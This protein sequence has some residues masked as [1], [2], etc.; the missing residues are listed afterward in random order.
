MCN[1][2]PSYPFILL[3]PVPDPPINPFDYRPDQYRPRP[4]PIRAAFNVAAALVLGFGIFTAFG[5]FTEQSESTALAQR[6]V[7]IME[8]RV[9]LRGLQLDK[10]RDARVALNAAKVKTGRLI[11]ANAVIQELD[12]G[13][14]DTAAI[15]VRLT[16]SNVD[17]TTVDDDG[18]VV[19]VEAKAGDYSILL[20]YI[21]LLEDVLQFV[22]VQVLK[23]AET[24]GDGSEGEL[25]QQTGEPTEGE[26]VV[27]MS[28]EI[29][30]IEI[31][32]DQL[33]SDEELASVSRLGPVR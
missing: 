32:V 1:Q 14:A 8:Q 7:G 12:A 13:F 31:D 33:V 24:S 23:L 20:A 5:V 21:W 18:R 11:A 6:M 10:T 3:G 28:L 2:M 17:L 16:P 25:V 15:I 9:E 30:R 19:A 26:T 27:E 4:L 29:T 22:H